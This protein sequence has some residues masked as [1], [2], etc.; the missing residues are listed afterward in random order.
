M[1]YQYCSLPG[2]STAFN[3][4]GPAKDETWFLLPYYWH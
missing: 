3:Q 2:T 4:A 1:F